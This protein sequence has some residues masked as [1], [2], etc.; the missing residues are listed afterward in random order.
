MAC[1]RPPRTFFL[2][3]LPALWSPTFSHK[4]R[5][6]PW[7]GLYGSTVS[8]IRFFT[9]LATHELSHGTVFKTKRLNESFLRLYS[10]V[11]WVNFHQYRLSHRQHHL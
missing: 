2:F 11:S 9:G 5:G 1:S 10:L 3:Y 4:V 6:L 7:L 8:A